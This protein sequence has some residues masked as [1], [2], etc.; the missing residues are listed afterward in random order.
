[1]SETPGRLAFLAGAAGLLGG[2][3]FT[4]FLLLLAPPAEG[5]R[6]WGP[7]ALAT[8]LCAAA[9]FAGLG[10]Q[11]G[12][13]RDSPPPA[14][15]STPGPVAAYALSFSAAPP[16]GLM[17]TAEA[18]IRVDE[19]LRL[20]AEYGRPLCIGL[21]GLDAGAEADLDD[22]MEAVRQL[23]AGAVRRPD[24]VADR[25]RAEILLLLVETSLTSGWVVAE[26]I[27]RRVSAA[28]VG[29][30]RAVLITPAADANLR[31][32]LE[33][34]DGGLDTCRQTGLI[35]AD[36]ARLLASTGKGGQGG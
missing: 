30:L 24:I 20:A 6:F 31:D 18:M 5:L 2:A 17:P 21:F 26:R 36:P 14:E 25:G 33:E 11:L 29:T 22:A 27:Q 9:A 10:L 34:L 3:I 32:V 7:A 1:M 4:A 16:G 8:V 23:T 35:F 13:R 12:S 19:E 15:A 28:G